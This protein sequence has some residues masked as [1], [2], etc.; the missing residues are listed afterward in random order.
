MLLNRRESE[1][2]SLRSTAEKLP[3][4]KGS[5]VDAFP[6]DI[7][8]LIVNGLNYV[9]R[10][11]IQ[12]Y[13]AYTDHLLDL[14]AKHFRSTAA[15]MFL[16]LKGQSIDQRFPPDLDGPALVEIGKRYA[17]YGTGSQDGLVFKKI[18]PS[19]RTTQPDVVRKIGVLRP[20]NRIDGAWSS[21][22]LTL[23]DQ[24]RQGSSLTLEFDGNLYRN[25][26]GA[27]FKPSQLWLEVRFADSHQD[28][29]R[30]IEGA[31]RNLPLVPMVRSN[32]DL[33][34]YLQAQRLSS[35][36]GATSSRPVALR[37][38]ELDPVRGV[39]SVRVSVSYP[40]VQPSL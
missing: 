14:N 5:T 11:V 19:P 27:L 37:L 6:W 22:W 7:T 28:K 15:P 31:S 35:G 36:V 4:P 26:V 3:I 39:R 34:L 24:L 21:D 40:A 12:S 38:L 30:V 9:P 18:L 13:S 10:P 25:A 23:P 8:D 32:G 17:F 1:L 2:L 20:Q 29:Y 16:V 33:R